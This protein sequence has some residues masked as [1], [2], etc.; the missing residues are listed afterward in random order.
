[1]T[2]QR[3]VIELRIHGVSGTPVEHILDTP[4]V[5]LH[6]GDELSGFSPPQVQPKREPTSPQGRVPVLE[7]YRWGGLTSRVATAALWVVLA[8]FALVNAAGAM[9]LTDTKKPV[10]EYRGIARGLEGWLVRLFALSLTLMLVLTAFVT[11][12]DIV[13]WQG[14][15][16][17]S[18]LVGFLDWSWLDTPEQRVAVL[19]L[20]P[21]VVLIGLARVGKKTFER[22]EDYPAS[23][24]APEV[25]GANAGT[26]LEC[27]DFWNG[28]ERARPFQRTHTAAGLSFIALLVAIVLTR[29]DATG[30]W[31]WI[32]PAVALGASMLLC[33]LPQ[34]SGAAAISVMI[35]AVLILGALLMYTY[36]EADFTTDDSLTLPGSTT[37]VQVMFGAQ[38]GTLMVL[39][40][41]GFYRWTRLHAFVHLRLLGTGTFCVSL[42]A[43]VIGAALSAGVILR[44]ADLIGRARPSAEIPNKGKTIVT[45]AAM[46]WAARGVTLACIGIV[47]LVVVVLLVVWRARRGHEDS[48]VEP[49]SLRSKLAAAIAWA[50][51]TD[52]ANVI[53]SVV[54]WITM[55]TAVGAFF[56]SREAYGGDQPGWLPGSPAVWRAFEVAGTVIVVLFALAL[57]F[58]IV[59]AYRTEGLRRKVGILWDLA[60]FWPR[61]AHPLGPPCYSERVVPELSA[62]VAYFLLGDA[63]I[64]EPGFESSDVVVSAHSQGSVIAAAALLQ[65][66]PTDQIALL[67]YGSPLRRLYRSYFP[68]Y[69]GDPALDVLSGRVG[70]RWRN[71]YRHT[72]PIGGPV[73]QDPSDPDPPP[74]SVDTF[75]TTPPKRRAGDPAPPVIERHSN[76]PR[77]PAYAVAFDWLDAQLRAQAPP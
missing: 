12:V 11:A 70:A 42:G 20:V 63:E 75:V 60:T 14:H 36:F 76:Y 37:T 47:V 53:I 46:A 68:T 6:A 23:K 32:V 28:A 71:L 17:G 59:R 48:E 8:P 73:F 44:V 27:A 67:S 52:R 35:A 69:F 51:L 77:E 66:A 43:F 56:A 41:F 15:R 64:P 40:A 18:G 3:R 26:P 74:A 7:G 16:S 58:L 19:A 22:Y 30:S 10:G 55:I 62:R 2:D 31:V 34:R 24:P 49:P 1:M 39:A 65:M 57:V 45:P 72:D 5:V 9:H 29:T 33:A 54:S 21:V 4:A 38:L 61:T 50:R 25:T 13:A